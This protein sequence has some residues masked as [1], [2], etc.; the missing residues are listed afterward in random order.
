MADALESELQSIQE[1]EERARFNQNSQQN[2]VLIESPNNLPLQIP[3]EVKSPEEIES[4]K[5][6][7]AEVERKRAEAA[8]RYAA[9]LDESRADYVPVAASN[10]EPEKEG[11]P[12]ASILGVV[13]SLAAIATAWWVWSLIQAPMSVEQMAESSRQIPVTQVVEPVPVAAATDNSVSFDNL[14][15]E[16]QIIADVMEEGEVGV[17]SMQTPKLSHFTQ[18]DEQ[19]K[20]SMVELEN[21]GLL[22]MELEDEIFENQW[23]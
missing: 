14:P 8:A 2:E 6:R 12:W 11:L 9:L 16:A 3:E 23:L 20:V 5:I 13:A 7:S 4:E 19:S 21:K 18:M 17:G 10:T 15:A 22:I 1:K